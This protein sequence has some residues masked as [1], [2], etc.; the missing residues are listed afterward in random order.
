MHMNIPNW[1]RKLGIFVGE[2]CIMAPRGMNNLWLLAN[3]SSIDNTIVLFP[4]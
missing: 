2:I 1:K 4:S 3:N